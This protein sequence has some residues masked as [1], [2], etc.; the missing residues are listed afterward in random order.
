MVNQSYIYNLVKHSD[1][2]TKLATLAI[3]VELKAEQDKIVKLQTYDYSYFFGKIFFGE[4]SF[5]NDY[6][7]TNI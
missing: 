6:L 3:K 7:S 2:N 5:Q 4:D 1:L